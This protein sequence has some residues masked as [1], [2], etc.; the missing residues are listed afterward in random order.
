M[1][2][3]SG[4]QRIMP[5]SSQDAPDETM[6][7]ELMTRLW[8]L[9][10]TLVSSDMDRAMSI[11][12]EYLPEGFEY[13]INGYPSGQKV[14]TWTVPEKYVVEE[15]YLD[16]VGPGP[17]RRVV[18]FSDNPLSIVSYSPAVDVELGLDELRPHLH[19]N[20]ERPGAIP[21]VFKYYD[22]D[23]GFCLPHAVL[24]S[25]PTDGRYRAVIRS[26]FD[27][28][29]LKVGELTIPGESDDFLLIVTD[30]CHPSQVNDSISGVVV[31]V[32]FAR[33]YAARLRQ[34]AAP[35]RYGLKILFLPETIGSVAW[36]ANNE[37]LI[38]R[39]KFGIFSEFI[40]HREKLR[41][42]RS[43]QDDHLI[44]RVARYVIKRHTNGDFIDGPFCHTIITNDEK[45]TNA[46][47]VDIPTIAL[48]RWPFDRY[49]T[50]DDNPAAILPAE[51]SQVS[52]IYDDIFNILQTNFYPRRRFRGPLF[53][54]GLKLDFDW[55]APRQLK[56]AVQDV[57]GNLDG[58]LSALDIAASV[59][60]DYELVLK[61]LGAMQRQNLIERH[62]E[63]QA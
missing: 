61:I 9:H 49:H 1:N 23:W 33:R 58:D 29:E 47:G 2:D 56:R 42:Q 39:M 32:D 63:K 53:L 35:G 21:W 11:I 44:D 7:M 14:W 46:P 13:R 55:K 31:A 57:A 27:T 52:R 25:L 34:G 5:A 18:D 59:G 19:S 24:E 17:R 62:W 43:R 6:M 16:L 36:L 51:L 37:N 60:L 45:V 38:D 50:T 3:L 48:N 28:G 8:P 10:R 4:A 12:G 30:V 15:A 41:L 20:K 54:S 22:R 40:G 26:R